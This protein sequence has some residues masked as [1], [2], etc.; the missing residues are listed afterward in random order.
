MKYIVI[1]IP[2]KN[3]S[4]SRIALLG[5]QYQLRFTWN[6]TGGYWMFGILDYLG[7]PLSIGTKVVPN[8][9]LNLFWGTNSTPLGVFAALTEVKDATSIQR[10]DF[11]NQKARF[12]FIPANQ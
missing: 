11:V 5:K 4:I 9:P 8:Y 7:N 12:I 6:D 3:D 2:D 1:E 10:N